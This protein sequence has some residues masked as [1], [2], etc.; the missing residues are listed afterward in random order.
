MKNIGLHDGLYN[1][2]Y[3]Y[4]EVEFV[5]CFSTFF[6]HDVLLVSS[7]Y[8]HKIKINLWKIQ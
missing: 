8:L 5:I 4:V 7:T 1:G 2:L 6:H 3:V